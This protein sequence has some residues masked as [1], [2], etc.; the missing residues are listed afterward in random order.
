MNNKIVLSSIISN[1]LLSS[2]LT[3]SI[4]LLSGYLTTGK[5]SNQVVEI[6]DG[7]SKIN[8]D[9]VNLHG[10]NKVFYDSFD[11]LKTEISGLRA[12][13]N[14]ND[15]D[16]LNKKVTNLEDSLSQSKIALKDFLVKYEKQID[17]NK[18]TNKDVNDIIKIIN[19]NS[20]K[21][22][23]VNATVESS[24]IFKKK[25]EAST[26]SL[27]EKMNTNAIDNLIKLK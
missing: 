24:L 26:T 3:T 22:E 23:K 21:I 6:P 14:S 12:K 10:K 8:K 16:A 27:N 7:I 1:V 5:D 25:L 20:K 4:I 11:L 17:F 9:L 13:L 2:A 18:L 15:F 19:Q